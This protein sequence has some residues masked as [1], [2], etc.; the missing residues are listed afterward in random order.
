[1]KFAFV[2][3]NLFCSNGL[4]MTTQQVETFLLHLTLKS[5]YVQITQDRLTTRWPR[6]RS[7]FNGTFSQRSQT[8]GVL[9]PSWRTRRKVSLSKWRTCKCSIGTHLQQRNNNNHV[10][11]L[12]PCYTFS[13]VLLLMTHVSCHQWFFK[14]FILHLHGTLGNYV[15]SC[16]ICTP[17]LIS[18]GWRKQGQDG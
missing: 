8:L 17:N 16:V 14:I 15:S 12:L 4:K 7:R 13:C 1:M 18:Y 5:A 10:L 2:I 6:P 3:L 9:F 11:L